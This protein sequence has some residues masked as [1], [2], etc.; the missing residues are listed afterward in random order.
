MSEVQ[1]NP[2]LP[3]EIRVSPETIE[4]LITF[5]ENE[6]GVLVC[7]YL[8]PGAAVAAFPTA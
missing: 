4:Q 1:F 5:T 8:S 6:H 7:A 3:D 2:Q